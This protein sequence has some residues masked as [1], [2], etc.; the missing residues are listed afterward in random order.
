MPRQAGLKLNAMSMPE[1]LKLRGQIQTALARKIEREREE[2]QAQID[3]LSALDLTGGGSRALV[4][5]GRPSRVSARS[6]RGNG[7]AHP[8]KG[9]TVAAKYRD[10][11]NSSQTWAGRGQAPRWLAAYEQQGRKRDEFLIGATGGAP[12]KGRRR[13]RA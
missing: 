10:P 1:L 9:R 2:L 12:T 13:K 6:R 11:E 3:R 4:S 8:L 5:R 7:R